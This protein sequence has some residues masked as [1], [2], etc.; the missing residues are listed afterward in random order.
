MS[1]R[2]NEL[3]KLFLR[4]QKYEASFAERIIA[5]ETGLKLSGGKPCLARLMRL[6]RS[7]NGACPGPCVPSCLRMEGNRGVAFSQ[8]ADCD[9]VLMLYCY[10]CDLEGPYVRLLQSLQSLP[11]LEAQTVGIVDLPVLSYRPKSSMVAVYDPD[12][13]RPGWWRILGQ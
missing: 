8:E 2:V 13:L 5:R 11:G 10:G 12:R 6:R 9:P 4:L 1:Q 3:E 7:C